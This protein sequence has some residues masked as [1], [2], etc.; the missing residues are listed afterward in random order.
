MVTT[1]HKPEYIRLFK[2]DAIGIMLDL[3]GRLMRKQ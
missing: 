1:V 3:L 2:S